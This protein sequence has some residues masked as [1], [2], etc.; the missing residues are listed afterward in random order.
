MG[1]PYVIYIGNPLKIVILNF[2]E[3]YLRVQKELEEK[4]S[5]WDYLRR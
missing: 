1:I 5:I 3:L 2:E 4:L